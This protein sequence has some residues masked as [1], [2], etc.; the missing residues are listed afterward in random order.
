MRRGDRAGAPVP[1]HPAGTGG[2]RHLRHRDRPVQPGDLEHRPVG[3]EEVP[4]TLDGSPDAAARRPRRPRARRTHESRRCELGMGGL[5][6]RGGQQGTQGPGVAG[7]ARSLR[8]VRAGER[9]P[10]GDARGHAR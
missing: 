7:A 1:V 5:C 4:S 10:R 8:A 3:E 2:R 9:G 6:R